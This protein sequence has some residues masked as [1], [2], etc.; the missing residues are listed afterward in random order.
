M[1]GAGGPFKI[2]LDLVRRERCE[3]PEVEVLNLVAIAV[4]I[5]HWSAWRIGR[6]LLLPSL[7]GRSITFSPSF[8][9]ATMSVVAMLVYLFGTIGG[10]SGVRSSGRRLLVSCMATTMTLY[11]AG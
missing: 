4:S 6:Y 7:S 2:R 3:R 11:F 5:D 1:C 9:S 8:T 10:G